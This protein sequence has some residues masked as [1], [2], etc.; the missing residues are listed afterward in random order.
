MHI[1]ESSRGDIVWRCCEH[2]LP[3]RGSTVGA[4]GFHAA[5]LHIRGSVVYMVDVARQNQSV[6]RAAPGQ[7][8]YS[9]DRRGRFALVY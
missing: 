2:A 5:V 4:R 8:Q 1:T 6:Q 3:L 9:V 7:M